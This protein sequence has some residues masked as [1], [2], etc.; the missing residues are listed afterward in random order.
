MNRW[1]KVLWTCALTKLWR[2]KDQGHRTATTQL[3]VEYPPN[4][5]LGYVNPLLVVH[6]M[7]AYQK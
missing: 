5:V 4:H 3:V 7:I 2:R 6:A 1:T